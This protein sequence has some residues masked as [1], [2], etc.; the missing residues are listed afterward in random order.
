ME[1]LSQSFE[2]WLDASERARLGNNF[3]PPL[4]R[5]ILVNYVCASTGTVVDRRLEVRVRPSIKTEKV[6]S[7]FQARSLAKT[8]KPYYNVFID[9]NTILLFG[10]SFSRRV[11][12]ALF[13]IFIN[14]YLS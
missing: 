5:V 12:N 4:T 10:L 14:Y 6:T 8:L 3:G 7:L 9:M 1:Q 11:L 2:W 13:I